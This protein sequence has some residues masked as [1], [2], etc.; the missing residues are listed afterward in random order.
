MVPIIIVMY[1]LFVSMLISLY[2]YSKDKLFIK[3][4][5]AI[6]S[7]TTIALGLF[8]YINTEK[9]R[10]DREKKEY[11]LSYISNVSSIFNKIDNLYLQYP[12]KLNDLFYEFYGFNNFPKNNKNKDKQ[13]PQQQSVKDDIKNN[14]VDDVTDIEYITINIL[15]EYINNI[16]ITNPEIFEDINFR[17]KLINYLRSKKFKTVMSF[18]RNN[19]SPEFIKLLNDQ[20]FILSSELSVETINVPKF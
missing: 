4:I 19:Y 12:D 16:F 5:V 20:N 11:S 6:L 13:A 2:V 10:S 18:T 15:I 3:D 8:N 9:E 17:N 7:G 1:L 14:L